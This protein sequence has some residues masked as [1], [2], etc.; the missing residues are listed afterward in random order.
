MATM[1]CACGKVCK[2]LKGLHIHQ[3]R[4]GCRRKKSQQQRTDVSSGETEKNPSQELNHSTG[5]L[6]AGEVLDN[7]NQRLL[8]DQQDSNHVE[9]DPQRQNP[10]DVLEPNTDLPGTK[11]K[12]N[13]INNSTERKARI[14]WPKT[15]EKRAWKQLDED[16]SVILDS[17]IQGPVDKKLKSLST[18]IYAVGKERFGITNNKPCK[19]IAQPN[20]RQKEIKKLREELRKLRKTFKKATTIEKEGLKQL[21]DDHRAQLLALRKAERIRTNR[22]KKAKKR[23]EFISNPYKFSKRLLDKER[24]GKLESSMEDIENYLKETHSDPMRDQPLG[25][26]PRVEPVPEPTNALDSSEPTLREVQEVVKKARSGSAPGPNGIP[27]KVYKMCPRLVR[28][29][30]ILLKTVWKKGKVP[31]CWKQAEGIFIPKEKNSRTVEEFRTISLLNVEGKIFFAILARR[32]TSYIT[33]NQYV[34]TSVQKGGVP[35]F[36]GCVEHTSCITQ[37]IREARMNNKDLTVVWLDLANAYGS[38]PHKLIEVALHHYHIPDHVKGLITEYLEGIHLRFT[39]GDKMTRWQRLEKG[40]VTGCT[41]SV[42]LFIMGMNLIINAGKRET[43]GP[44]TDSGVYVPSSRGFMDDMT[45][46]TTSPIQARWMLTAL[47]ETVSWARMKFKAKKSR[48]L[49]I[50][51]GQVSQRFT[52]QVQGENIPSIVESPIKCLGKWFDSS[53]KDKNNTA[54]VKQQLQEGLKQI[55]QTGLPGKFKTWLYQH[56]LL[57]RLLWPL[58]LY[59]ITSTAVE[60]L[61][62]TINRHLRRWLGVPPSFSS[63]GLYGRSNQLQLPISSVMEEYKVSKAR[64]VVTLKDSKD[65]MIRKAGIETRTGRK[66]SASRAVQQA[67]SR[68]RHKDIVGTTAV[69]RQGLGTTSTQRWSTA[70]DVEKR[71]M[72]QNE[73]RLS[74]EETRKARAVELGLQGAWTRWSTTERKLTW[75]DLWQYEPLRLSFLLRSVYDLLPS[76]ANL[77]RWGLVEDPRCPLCDKKGT[78]EHVLSSCQVALTQGRYRWRHDKVLQELA[79]TLDRERRRKR[80]TKKTREWI[81]FVKEGQTR[82]TPPVTSTSVLDESDH[83]EMKADLG[84]RLVFPDIVHTTQRPDIVIWSP[85]NK[86]LVVIELTVPWETRCEEAFERKKTKYTELVEQCQQQGWRCWL[87]PVEVGARGFA[88]QS[89]WKTLGNLGVKGQERKGTVRA[90]CQAAERASSW[91]WLRREEKSWKLSTDT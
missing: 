87:F 22:R 35:G 83:W 13:N 7:S 53:L 66:W 67:E 34:D 89:L 14:A 59:E 51:R 76:P 82:K 49:I 31:D 18:I 30:W 81:S 73:I 52:L 47:E 79:S 21:R 16:L 40:I 43:R 5:D 1:E 70:S 63:I 19:N 36:S 86:K 80:E 2:N 88:A 25:D 15:S 24:S 12:D 9:D 75:A 61:E 39:V 78:M 32:M 27:Y 42:V 91:L 38:I 41:I 65:E 46:T 56:G 45:L 85:N 20:R 54:Q 4:S 33:E 48:S 64:M 10:Q 69:G 57:P 58:M 50:K 62:R 84:R 90:V 11:A 37:L 71:K 17:A 72:I 3:T 6:L 8:M 26:C 28:R 55:D 68:L 74:E 60:G 44:K 23:A 77:H 29:L